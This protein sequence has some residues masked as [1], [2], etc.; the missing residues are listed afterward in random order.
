MGVDIN[1][2]YECEFGDDFRLVTVV[3]MLK[4]VAALFMVHVVCTVAVLFMVHVS[5]PL[6][7]ADLQ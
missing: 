5:V 1:G 2:S 7:G 3:A 6:V 4:R